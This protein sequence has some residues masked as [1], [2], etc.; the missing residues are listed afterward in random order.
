VSNSV[1]LQAIADKLGYPKNK[2]SLAL[3]NSPQETKERI[4]RAASKL[5]C[6]P[7]AIVA[8]SMAELRSRQKSKFQAK[9]DPRIFKLWILDSKPDIVLTLYNRVSSWI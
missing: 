3:H 7:N 6:R 9:V 2:I 5:G 1:T 4:Q 8:C